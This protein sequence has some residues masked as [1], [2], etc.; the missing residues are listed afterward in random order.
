MKKKKK[1][2]NAQHYAPVER[3]RAEIRASESTPPK[4]RGWNSRTYMDTLART[5]AH[6][7]IHVYTHKAL[8]L[9]LSLTHTHIHTHMSVCA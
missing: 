2:T 8:S 5:H 7:Y 6:I 9:S 1:E 3:G 4:Y